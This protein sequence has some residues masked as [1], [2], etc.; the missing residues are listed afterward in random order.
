MARKNA[1]W[2]RATPTRKE[3]FREKMKAVAKSLGTGKNFTEEE[4]SKNARKGWAKFS[5]EQRKARANIAIEARRRIL[6]RLSPEERRRWLARGSHACSEAQREAA[7]KST[8]QWWAS[9][10]PQ[11]REARKAHLRQVLRERNKTQHLRMTPEQRERR[12]AKVSES[13]LAWWR[14]ASPELVEERNEKISRALSGRVHRVEESSWPR[15]PIPQYI[16]TRKGELI[17]GKQEITSAQLEKKWQNMKR[18]SRARTII[19]PLPET[20]GFEKDEGDERNEIVLTDT[21][22][23]L[24]SLLSKER[25]EVFEEAIVSLPKFQRLVVEMFLEGAEDVDVIARTICVDAVRVKNAYV[26]ALRALGTNP[27][28]RS[29]YEGGRVV[30]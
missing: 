28:V 24:D 8:T 26:R 15:P 27:K 4:R 20:V 22:T 6:D 13:M 5:P 14:N 11:E 16:L 3:A 7:R 23:P 17:V 19:I 12:Y 9:L 1:F 30:V 2:E 10:S 18:K 29:L 25:R 21:V